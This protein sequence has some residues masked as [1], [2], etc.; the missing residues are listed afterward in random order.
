MS[1]NLILINANIV[2]PQGRP[3]R[4]GEAMLELLN[5]PCG[6]V[7]VADGIITYVGELRISHE[8]PG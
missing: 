3:A 2:T 1:N 6:T 8:K 7:R 5:I 4:K